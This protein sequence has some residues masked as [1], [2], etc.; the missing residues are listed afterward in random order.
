MHQSFKKI[1]SEV[2]QHGTILFAV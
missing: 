1:I 2:R